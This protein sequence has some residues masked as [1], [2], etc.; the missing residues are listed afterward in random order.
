MIQTQVSLQKYNTFGIDA[1]TDEFFS[2]THT[3]ELLE[4][5]AVR[6]LQTSSYFI[7]GGGSNVLFLSDY[8]GIVIHP[9]N[10]GIQIVQ[11]NETTVVV[12]VAAGEVWDDFVLWSIT[13]S[14]YGLENLSYIPGSVG[15]SAVQNIGAYGAEAKDYIRNVHCVNLYSGEQKILPNSKCAYGYRESIFKHKDYKHY[16]IDYVEFEL[17]KTFVAR[18]DYGDI[19]KKLQEKQL[20]LS[21]LNLRNVIIE[22]RKEKLPNPVETP[23]AGSFFKNPIITR[24]Q[25]SALLLQYPAMVAYPLANGKVKVAAGWLIDALGLKGYEMQHAKIHDKQAL[26]I[27]NT[28]KASGNDIK[29]L[30]DFVI[31]TVL[32]KT[33]IRLELEVIFV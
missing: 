17:S 12:R 30:S 33:N 32:N 4:F 11:D 3:Q 18:S 6:D 10:K 16:I 14:Y 15:A 20:S 8:K 28:G 2:F 22:I 31:A 25:Y 24:E 29:A 9:N 1:H 26:V 19:Q 23:N 5:I 7:L 27:V 21:A 13:N